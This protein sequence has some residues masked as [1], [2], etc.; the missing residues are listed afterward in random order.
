MTQ[1]CLPCTYFCATC[2]NST[3]TCLTCP[4]F[5]FR[6]LIGT[7][8]PCIFGYYDNST[9]VCVAC[10]YSCFGCTGPDPPLCS[11]C[12]ASS[13]R[14]LQTNGSCTCNG[15]FYDDGSSPI[16]KACSPY[17]VNCSSFSVCLS[18]N[19][20]LL[21]T[22]SGTICAC[23][24]SLYDNGISLL[25]QPCYYTCATCFGGTSTSCYTCGINRQYISGSYSC[26]CNNGFYETAQICYACDPTCQICSIIPTNCTSCN[27]AIRYLNNSQCLCNTGYY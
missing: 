1:V 26:P 5:T 3:A 12:P 4:L 16:C 25:C 11:D 21:R 15:G 20:A 13:Y 7:N 10:P 8:C 23:N 14:T 9:T 22:L 17:C 2:Q 27:T 6:L 24:T 19:P 18:C